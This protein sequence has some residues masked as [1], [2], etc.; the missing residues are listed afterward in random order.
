MSKFF[1]RESKKKVRLDR[2]SIESRDSIETQGG[3]SVGTTGSTS[4]STGRGPL[5][6]PVGRVNLGFFFSLEVQFGGLIFHFGMLWFKN[7]F[8]IVF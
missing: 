4:T 3:D 2:D 1:S 6:E 7:N 8:F 5:G